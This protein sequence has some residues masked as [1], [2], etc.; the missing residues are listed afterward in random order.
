ML[1][2]IKLLPASCKCMMKTRRPKE[3]SSPQQRWTEH[4]TSWS[5]LL[6]WWPSLGLVHNRKLLTAS[7]THHVRFGHEHR[8]EIRLHLYIICSV[9]F[10]INHQCV[11]LLDKTKHDQLLE[12]VT[13]VLTELCQMYHTYISI[14]YKIVPNSLRW[15]IC[16]HQKESFANLVNSTLNSLMWWDSEGET[17]R[18]SHE[19]LPQWPTTNMLFAWFTFLHNWSAREV[20]CE[21]TIYRLICRTWTEKTR[22]WEDLKVYLHSSPVGSDRWSA[23]RRTLNS[24][25][26]EPS[27]SPP[28]RESSWSKKKGVM[29]TSW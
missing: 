17:S 21:C 6:P 18:L 14:F 3:W 1:A 27:S 2:N 26:D 5:A 25:Q 22:R 20:N 15:V 24:D 28:R 29:C 4:H 8:I 23:N 13:K 12:K 10:S 11:G 9:P 19:K 16:P 7:H